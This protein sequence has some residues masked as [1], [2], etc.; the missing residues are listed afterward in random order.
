VYGLVNK[1]IKEFVIL[2]SGDEVWQQA[3]KEL[4]LSE[5]QFLSLESNPDGITFQ[6]IDHVCRQ[7][8]YPPNE[9]A[10][11]VGE[12]FLGFA[13]KEG[14]EDLME[15]SGDTLPELLQNLNDLHFRVKTLMPNL[16]PPR[17]EVSEQT[18][19]SLKLHYYSARDG[20]NLF[21]VGILK[22]LAKK[23]NLNAT[24]TLLPPVAPG[25]KCIISISWD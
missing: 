18:E 23:F 2:H 14:F 10:E 24:L 7:L 5:T 8:N 19:H 20:L 3:Y 16:N 12:Y 17:F 25:E 6:I 15:L 1:A 13:A 11:H 9:F 4:D 21:L 22:G